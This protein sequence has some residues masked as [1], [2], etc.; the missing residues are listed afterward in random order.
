[1]YY[2]AHTEAP[3]APPAT[4]GRIQTVSWPPVQD[5]PHN[6]KPPDP[7]TPNSRKKKLNLNIENLS[8]KIN[9]LV[10]D[11]EEQKVVN[12]AINLRIGQDTTLMNNKNSED[13]E[14]YI[15]ALRIRE[16]EDLVNSLLTEIDRYKTMGD[17]QNLTQN[18]LRDFGSPIKE[19]KIEPKIQ[20]NDSEKNLP[21]KNDINMFGKFERAEPFYNNDDVSASTDMISSQTFIKSYEEFCTSRS[22]KQKEA[23]LLANSSNSVNSDAKSTPPA[24]CLTPSPPPMPDTDSESNY[25]SLPPPPFPE[26]LTIPF[27][28]ANP[29]S[30][31]FSPPPPLS[32]NNQSSVRV[33]DKTT[34]PPSAVA[35]P[36]PPPPPP[37]PDLDMGSMGPP[38][39]SMS[40]LGPPPPPMSGMEPYSSMGPPPLPLS[41]MGP[42]PPP[43]SGMEPYPSMGPP[44]PP[45][46]GMGPPPPP[47][48]GMEPY[49][50]T[51]PPPPPMSGMG[52][53]PPPMS[54]MEGPP[55]PPPPPMSGMGGPPP[56]PM[57]GMGGP[58]PPPPMMGMGGPPPPPMMGMGGPPPPPM[59]GMGGPPPPPM[60]GG[61]PP[62]PPA[63]GGPPPP[64]GMGPI[65]F[66]APP[67][68][69]WQH[70]NKAGK[71]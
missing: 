12:E 52:P 65:P 30:G 25:P 23:S 7:M 31:T 9:P 53:P 2:W 69:G 56:P 54:G 64:P 62:P 18:A 38:P 41:G 67:V 21:E 48:S 35:G 27:E 19:K 43:I 20:L 16:L 40:G 60:N 14:P 26:D 11:C 61:G 22:E 50:S 71:T 24:T 33:A 5:I 4:P 44:P 1:M 32:E 55:P 37:M 45:M 63:P 68:G 36:P 3:V 66:P 59:M 51:G 58:P 42:P 29:E 47:M 46:S 17:I 57:S 13:K 15:N 34:T 8:N 49:P 28:N 39:P 10:K 70:P 6:Q